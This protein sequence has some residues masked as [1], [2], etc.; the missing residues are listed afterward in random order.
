MAGIGAS[1]LAMIAGLVMSQRLTS[2]LKKLG[3]AAVRMGA[4]DL[5]ARARVQSQDEIGT[6]AAQFNSMADQ[7]QESFLQL[8][9]ERDSL[10]RFIA[11]ASHELRTPVT[12][13]KNF[14]TLL[15]GSAANDRRAQAEFLAESQSQVER[16]EW[17][18][19]NLLDLTRLDAGLVELDL[20]DH[21]LREILASAATSF[22]PIAEGKGIQLKMEAP[23]SQLLL[24]CDR[25]RLEL[26]LDNLLDNALKFT[27]LGG[28]IQIGAGM[29]EGVTRTWVQD[30]G[31][32]IHPDD[33]PHIFER[34]YRGRGRTDDGS[35]LGLA[36]VKSLVEAQ[37]GRV[38]VQSEA[39][40]GT[41]ITL[42]WETSPDPF[43]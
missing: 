28:N 26:A 16:L 12:A 40:K 34:F 21:D 43:G 9:A 23:E 27:P 15:Q 25:P 4:G 8:Q 1:V 7:L 14:L 38:G 19:R 3:E 41:K 36:I 6:L 5:T 24:R 22:R 10:R 2:P 11:D 13:L 18:T 37:G 42:E 33:L 17:I 30:S 35:G 29:I 31:P 20:A 39:G 32:G